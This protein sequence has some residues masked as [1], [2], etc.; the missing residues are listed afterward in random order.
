[1]S[2]IT[3]ASEKMRPPSL[4]QWSNVYKPCLLIVDINDT[5]FV[6]VGNGEILEHLFYH[7][8]SPSYT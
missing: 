5:D 7:Q 1:M 4:I 3:Y 2:K 6:L 8:N